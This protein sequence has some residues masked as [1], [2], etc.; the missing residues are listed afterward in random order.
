MKG[1]G[2]TEYL[3]ILAVVLIVALVVIG[4]LGW[5]PGVAGSAREQQSAT[6][7]QGAS[8]FS[9]TAFKMNGTTATLAVANRLSTKL[10]L[11]NVSFDGTDLA[12][13]STT[14]KGG[15]EKTVTGTL[16]ASCGSAG[17][18]FEYTTVVLTYTQGSI[19]GIKQ[20]GDKPLI[21]K[22]S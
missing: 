16:G 11:T 18:P 5:F 22:C 8:P 19:T 17:T 10:T 20:T 7:W 4:L 21:G 3:V 2:A 15:E 14:F 1:Q 6:Y 12:V 13:G 9:I